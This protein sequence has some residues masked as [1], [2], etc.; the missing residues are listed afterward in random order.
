MVTNSIDEAVLLADRVIPVVPGPPATLGSPIPVALARPRSAAQLA[1]DDQAV[2]TRN[3]V[4]A[5]LTS[6]ARAAGGPS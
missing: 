5:R 2:D 3:H 1:H 6:T 4:I